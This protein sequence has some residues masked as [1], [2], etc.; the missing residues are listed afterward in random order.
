MLSTDNESVQK[1]NK[2]GKYH[3]ITC[4]CRAATT[5]LLKLMRNTIISK[6]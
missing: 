2:V 4:F 1:T 3:K 5:N 6:L